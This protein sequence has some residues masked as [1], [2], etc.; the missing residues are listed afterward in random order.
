MKE[1]KPLIVVVFFA[2][3]VYWGVEPFAHHAMHKKVDANGKEIVY[4]LNGFTYPSLKMPA[5]IKGNAE[6]GKAL[7]AACVGCHSIKSQNMPAPMDALASAGAY[8]V[9]PPDLS[10][11]GAIYDEAFLLKI[12][13]RKKSLFQKILWLSFVKSSSKY[14]FPLLTK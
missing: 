8:G 6:N 9:N 12:N 11:T 10:N 4:K 2:L 13:A 1:L 7:S 3:V 5:G 14:L